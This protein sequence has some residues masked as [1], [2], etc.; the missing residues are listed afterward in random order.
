MMAFMLDISKQDKLKNWIMCGNS[1][2]YHL[3]SCKLFKYIAEN[4]EEL[5]SLLISVKEESEREESEKPSLKLKIQK[6]K[7]TTKKSYIFFCSSANEFSPEM[8]WS[9]SLS[10]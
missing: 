10:L 5:K 3:L 9:V 7:W 4:E 2:Q 6:T 1:A 8:P